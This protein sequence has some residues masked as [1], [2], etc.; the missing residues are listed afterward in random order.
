M[1][2][3]NF[4][5]F[6]NPAL[7]MAAICGLMIGCVPVDDTESGSLSVT[8]GT[9]IIDGTYH[10]AQTTH[11]E[12]QLGSDGSL[13]IRHFTWDA[14]SESGCYDRQSTSNTWSDTIQGDSTGTITFVFS[15]NGTYR[16]SCDSSWRDTTMSAKGTYTY[17]LRSDTLGFRFYD[18][19]STW[20]VMQRM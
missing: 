20:R 13:A 4:V 17:A 6:P 8:A 1:A 5:R 11:E 3:L 9:Y 7:C 12:W 2:R 16:S 15:G 10:S 14:S 18:S 19:T